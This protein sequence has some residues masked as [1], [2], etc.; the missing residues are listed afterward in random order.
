MSKY[1]FQMKQFHLRHGESGMKVGTD[2]LLLGAWCPLSGQERRVLDIGS[3]C[4]ILSLMLAQRL[5]DA[6]ITGVEIDQGS[7][8]ESLLNVEESR[9][10]NRIK[11]IMSDIRDFRTPGDF[12]LIVS[13][14]PYFNHLR[15]ASDVRLKARHQSTLSVSDLMISIERLLAPDGSSSLILPTSQE[16]QYLEI[17][18]KSNL[19]PRDLVYLRHSS[20]AAVKRMLIN[21]NRIKSEVRISE[22]IIGDYWQ[23][24]HAYRSLLEPFL[25]SDQIKKAT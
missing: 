6:E 18:A 24:S 16:M 17:A 5:P 11:I 13:N 7:F 8:Q 1:I 2:S 23:R 19:Y 14:P 15:P 12:D 4:G 9:W 22:L 25:L 3:G 20:T 10:K 21:L